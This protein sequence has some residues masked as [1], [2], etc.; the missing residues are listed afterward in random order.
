MSIGSG[1]TVTL[2]VNDGPIHDP[3]IEIGVITYSTVPDDELLGFVNTWLITGPV[4]SVA[5]IIPPVIAPMVHENVLGS[6]AV[7][8]MFVLVSLHILVVGELVMTGKGL[9]TITIVD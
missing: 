6:V 2:I 7:S 3:L 8:E 4:S 9:I 1:F 5:P